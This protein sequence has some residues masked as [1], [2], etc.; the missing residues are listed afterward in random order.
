MVL[1][2]GGLD[3]SLKQLAIRLLASQPELR[4]RDGHIKDICSH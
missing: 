2:E 4:A 1:T 3:K